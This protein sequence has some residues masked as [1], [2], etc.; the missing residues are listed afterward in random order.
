VTR[1]IELKSILDV[2]LDIQERSDKEIVVS[3]I[4]MMNK[5]SCLSYRSKILLVAL[6]LAGLGTAGY[7]A[8]SG[9]KSKVLQPDLVYVFDPFLLTSTAVTAGEDGS[10]GS[11]IS[12]DIVPLDD[13]PPIRIPSR[14]ALRSPFRPPLS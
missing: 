10:P 6:V 9:G 3:E 12:G 4:S 5:K 14:P 7:A 13:R 2:A 1:L 11:V 8:A